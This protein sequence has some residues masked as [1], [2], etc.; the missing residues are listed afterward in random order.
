MTWATKSVH[1]RHLRARRVVSAVGEAG[2]NGSMTEPPQRD[3]SALMPPMASEFALHAW[4]DESIHDPGSQAGKSY[5][6]MYV[7]AAVIADPTCCEGPRG[8]LRELVPRG[9]GRLHWRGESEPQR[10]KIIAAI[11]ACDMVHAVVV[12]VEMR[13][14]QQERARRKCMQRLLFQLEA[15]GVSQVW[16]ESRTES[17]NRRDMRLVEQ[18][19]GERTISRAI[20]V[21]VA[22]PSV[23]PMLWVPDAVAGAVS[24]ARKGVVMEHRDALASMIEEHEIQLD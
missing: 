23:E 18:L 16:L 24:A 12:G 9:A 6:G 19:R 4:V 10:R 11:A 3:T 22:L 20:R 17:L 1:A 8:M 7:M 13:A 2:D 14:G 21:D 15:V 5:V